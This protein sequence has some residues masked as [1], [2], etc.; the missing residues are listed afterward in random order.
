MHY[1]SE[2]REE[3]GV[4][5]VRIYVDGSARPIALFACVPGP[6][7]IAALG[8]LLGLARK[9]ALGAAADSSSATDV[10]LG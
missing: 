1:L 6:G 4:V 2:I 5:S 10:S 8:E 3:D 7:G 9:G